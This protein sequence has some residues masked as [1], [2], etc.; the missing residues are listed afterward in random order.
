[1]AFHAFICPLVQLL[2][3]EIFCPLGLE[4]ERVAAQ[5]QRVDT[6]HLGEQKVL[7]PVPQLIAFIQ[8]S[9]KCSADQCVA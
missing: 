7:P 6:I 4:A 5:I 3:D 2:G 9:G 8:V 1:M